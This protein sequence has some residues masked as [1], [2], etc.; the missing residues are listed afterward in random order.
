MAE[1][2]PQIR[3]VAADGTRLGVYADYTKNVKETM[4]AAN[5]E[6][7]DV[8]VLYLGKTDTDFTTGHTYTCIERDGVYL[9]VD[10][11]PVN[12]SP[13]TNSN[14]V[15]SVTFTANGESNILL[16]RELLGVV[17]DTPEYEIVD[18][19]GYNITSDARLSRRW[20]IDGYLM[21][22]LGGWEPGTYTAKSCIGSTYSRAELDARFGF[23]LDEL[24]SI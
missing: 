18:E 9:W 2:R 8:T 16:T 17:D 11:T 20:T 23:I 10:V 6:Y 21:T 1:N 7:A 5:A 12:T 15:G 3:L 13:G 14:L 22:F 4:P 19:N 24:R